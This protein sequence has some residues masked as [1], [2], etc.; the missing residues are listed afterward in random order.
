MTESLRLDDIYGYS[1]VLHKIMSSFYEVFTKKLMANLQAQLI[2]MAVSFLAKPLAQLDQQLGLPSGTLSGLV[3]G[4]VMS[5]FIPGFNLM[6]HIAKII[7]PIILDKLG[8]GFLSSFLFNGL[9]GSLFGFGS[10][11]R[12]EVWCAMDYYPYLEPE[13]KYNIAFEPV[14]GQ[15]DPEGL[16]KLKPM[17]GDAADIAKDKCKNK[18]KH[19]KGEFMLTSNDKLKAKLK[20]AAKFKATQ[21]VGELLRM[22][23]MLNNKD[24]LPAQIRTP[25]RFNYAPYIGKI[26]KLYG[27]IKFYV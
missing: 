2:T 9:L 20:V 6:L 14:A 26:D 15:I 27:N 18:Y 21:L 7:V 3:A 16:E 25:L 19:G 10:K 1:D 17:V 11:K 4:L 23:T 8:L 12:K 24:M 5:M 13:V 22:P